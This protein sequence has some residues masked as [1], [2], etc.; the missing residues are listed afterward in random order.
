MDNFF[1]LY[2]TGK[3]QGTG[4]GLASAK[5]YMERIGGQIEARLVDGDCVEFVLYFPLLEPIDLGASQGEL[6]RFF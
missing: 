5:L 2:K 3:V 6:G 1:T 4:F